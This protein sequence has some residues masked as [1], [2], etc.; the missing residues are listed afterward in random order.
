[1][2]QVRSD[3]QKA[4]IVMMRVEFIEKIDAAISKL[5]Y[6]DRASLIR[7]AVYQML[8]ANNISVTVVDK[9]IPGRTGKGGRPKKESTAPKK[10]SIVAVPG[11]GTGKKQGSTPSRK[12]AS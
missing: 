11:T 5:G 6:N 4:I 9:T 1:M 8:K 2:P 7:D 3:G 12:T 10:P